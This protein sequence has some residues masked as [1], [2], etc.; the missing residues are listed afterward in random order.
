MQRTGSGGGID[1]LCG[2]NEETP[3]Q[4]DSRVLFNA[5]KRTSSVFGGGFLTTEL[6]VSCEL[7]PLF[8]WLIVIG[9]SWILS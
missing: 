5:L 9:D 7:L 2:F 4:N 8:G 6:S 1:G 3:Q